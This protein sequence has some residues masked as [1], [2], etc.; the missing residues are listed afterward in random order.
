MFEQFSKR[1]KVLDYDL[2]YLHII[3]RDSLGTQRTNETLASS[4]LQNIEIN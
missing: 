1:N 3:F 4:I 2:N